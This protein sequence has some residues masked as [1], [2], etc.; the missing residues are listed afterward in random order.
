M[1]ARLAQRFQILEGVGLDRAHAIGE[2][3]TLGVMPDRFD[4]AGRGIHA[5]NF[6][7]T[8]GRRAQAPSAE[9]A[10]HIEHALAGN[11]GGE[12]VAI[13]AL[14]VEPTGLLPADRVDAEFQPA[15]ARDHRRAQLAVT[16]VGVARQLF[17]CAD[18]GIVLPDDCARL[19]DLNDCGGDVVLEPLHAG[20]GGLAD[21][22]VA[23]A[24]QG[25]ARQAIGFA[26]HE[27][28]IRFGIQPFAQAECNF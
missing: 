20:R 28:V 13:A 9:I 4:R 11:V 27:P 19:D 26:E 17:H 22:H 12:L 16:D 21:D 7:G 6:A 10:E 23:V 24:I 15:F 8:A 3:V 25:Q 14:I 1:F 2:S 18:A 5:H